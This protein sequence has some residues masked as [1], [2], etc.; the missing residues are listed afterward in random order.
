MLPKKEI[1]GVLECPLM[2]RWTV[3]DFG[4]IKG[5]LHYFLPTQ[6]DRDFH[7]HPR[8]FVTFILRGGYDDIQLDGTI[9]CVRAPTVRQ[10]H[11]EHAHITVAGAKGCWTFVIMGPKVREWGFFRL[12]RWWPWKKYEDEFGM[13]FRCE[14][15]GPH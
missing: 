12:G 6:R 15:G 7:D 13:S 3:F 9:D 1:I 2:F 8:S 4:K 11:A 5:M 14:E 10:R